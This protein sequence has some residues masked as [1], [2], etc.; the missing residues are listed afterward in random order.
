K[1]AILQRRIAEFDY[2]SAYGEK[3]QRRIEP[4]QLRFYSKSWYVKGFCLTRQDIR[5]FKLSR[6][7][8]LKITD[9]LFTRRNSSVV[10]PE[11]GPDGHQEAPWVEM[12]FKIAPEM[13]YRV[14]D[15]FEIDALDRQPD[16]SFVITVNWPQSEWSYGTVL[17][18][19]QY[20]E[21]LEPE[22]IRDTIREN[23][24]L[25]SKIYL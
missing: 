21:V 3:T 18:Y 13:A 24:R 22:E 8:N 11:P 25:A 1:T 16:G 14:Y 4:L 12:K 20:I 10:P 2:Y 5:L 9:E 7:K 23:L 6:V 15:E 17:S 19:G